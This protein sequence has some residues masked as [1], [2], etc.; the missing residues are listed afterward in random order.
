MYAILRCHLR[1]VLSSRLNTL[2]A[3]PYHTYHYSY[4]TG[5]SKLLNMY[6]ED[7]ETSREKDAIAAASKADK[8][9]RYMNT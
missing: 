3:I 8:E 1:V 9:Y 5:C 6:R 7:R 2:T 4:G